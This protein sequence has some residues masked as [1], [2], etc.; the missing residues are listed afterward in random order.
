MLATIV[1]R[2]AR[3][4]LFG[5]A[6]LADPYPSYARLRHI[7][8]VHWAEDPGSW[9]L[10]QY[11]D[12]VSVLRSPHASAERTAIA[13]RRV[14]AE[15][16][17]LFTSRK[18]AM[19]N[20]DPPRH[21]R[22]RLLVNKAF[23]PGAVAALA[24]FIQRFVD[25]VLD[26]VQPRGRMDVIRDLAYPLPATVIAEMLGVPHADRD[27][28]KQWSDDIAAIAGNLP[29]SLSEDVLRR[30]L[31]GQRELRAYFAGIVAQRR[32]EP[33][34]DLISALVKAQDEGER[35]NEAELLANAVLLLNAGHETTTN[36]IG[37]GTL[38]LL[39]HPDQLRRLR[40]DPTLIP[41]AI[42]E[43][44]R[45]DS[46][47]QFTS[48][49]LK[50]DLS[51]GGK[52][53]RT[54]QTVLLLLGAANR[55]PAQFPDPDRLDVGR[56]DNKHLAFGLGS[57][58]CL[59]APLARLEGRIVFETLLRRLPGLRLTGPAPVYRQNFNLRGLEALEVAF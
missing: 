36:L 57:H 21:T 8:P 44:L 28:F 33:R 16:Q 58:F 24:L 52:R 13:Q 7:D 37:N 17:E 1:K 35:L 40:A 47:V 18:D 5:P 42:E 20:A 45:Y 3:P 54:G 4:Q 27:R 11:A 10:T 38:A 55:D 23:T 43:L 51:L 25:D 30:G 9:V 2:L 15:F 50:V 14:P 48:R 53:L 26:T 31:E 12:I 22:L 56:V 39:R 59:G 46:P 49:V 6:M 19:L 34:D 41:T 29:G 32:V